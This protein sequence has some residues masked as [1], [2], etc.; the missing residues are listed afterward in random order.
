M[1]PIR[2]MK[3]DEKEY[4]RLRRNTLAKI[5]RVKS[6][7]GVDLSNEVD[8]THIDDFS[9][10]KQFNE[11]KAKQSR[12]TNIGTT[13]YQFQ[14]NIHGVV[15][16][17]KQ[18][19]ALERKTRMAQR[20]AEEFNKELRQKPFVRD[21][22]V[23]GTVG[24]QMDM[25]AKPDNLGINKMSDFDFD[26]IKDL[27]YLEDR[28]DFLDRITKDDYL[29]SRMEQMKINFTKSLENSFTGDETALLID[30]IKGMNSD[31]FYEMY[32]MFDRTEGFDFTLYDSDGQYVEANQD[33]IEKMLSNIQ[34]YEQGELNFDLKDF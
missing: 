1:T 4:A 16:N 28:E 14:E 25:V 31:Y 26:K 23:V 10:R 21:G 19:Y 5:R 12:F 6:K 11:W 29:E 32:M 7:Y 20:K 3:K 33:H 15:A 30:K 34:M 13:E 17:K 8:L 2:I 18:L 24:N 9:T 22:Q 27:S